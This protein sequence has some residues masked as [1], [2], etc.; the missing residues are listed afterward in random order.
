MAVTACWHAATAAL[1]A[2]YAQGLRDL[3]FRVHDTASQSP[4]H[5]MPSENV[6]VACGGVEVGGVHEGLSH[7]IPPGVVTCSFIELCCSADSRLGATRPESADCARYRFTERE[8]LTS[9]SGLRA[10]LLA[11]NESQARSKGH[12]LVWVS[13]PCT[14]GCPWNRVTARF[15]SAQLK[16]SAHIA[17][18]HKLWAACARVMEYAVASGGPR[19]CDYWKLPFVQ[20]FLSKHE[21]TQSYFDGVYVW[22]SW[23]PG[24]STQETLDCGHKFCFPERHS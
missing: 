12:L 2:A 3:G 22:V 24:S 1:S 6:G 21:L 23:P 15:P 16:K 14:G 17:L 10:A 20:K 5:D 8:D 9:A 7:V 19:H 18:F 13:I 11:V 4:A